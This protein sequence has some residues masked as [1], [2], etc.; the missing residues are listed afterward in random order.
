M[1]RPAKLQP[2]SVIYGTNTYL[3]RQT[4][5]EVIL[6]EL[7]GGDP[8][9]NLVRFEGPQAQPAQVLDDVRTFSMLGERRVVVVDEAD[10]FLDKHREVLERYLK[11]PADSGCLILVCNTFDA[12]TR[13]FKAVKAGGESVE[14]KPLRGQAVTAWIVATARETYGKGMSHLAAKRLCD[15]VGDSQEALDAEIDKLATYVGAR[16]EIDVPD[17]DAVVG[18]YREQ[19][20]FAVMDAI[21]AGDTV[22][23]L[24]EW[25]QVL[26]TDRAA[27]GRAIGGLAWALRRLL[28]A[29]RRFD[30]G[31][32]V[33][34]LAREQWTD[35][36][37]LRRRMQRN[38]IPQL[39][40]RLTDLL[41]ADLESKNGLGSVASAV[42]KFIVKHSAVATGG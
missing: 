18:N 28:D 21:A 36:E 3:R 20:V 38:S 33:E 25:Q 31:T 5:H 14:C 15:H 6:R 23:A 40:N 42:E 32:A 17:V 16:R 22:K 34:V 30:G 12:R 39:E 37:T 11:A 26:A 19:N 9:L 2:I 10:G 7:A 4:L 35:V 29:R 27:P 8:G 41:N 24:Q 1:G 13:L